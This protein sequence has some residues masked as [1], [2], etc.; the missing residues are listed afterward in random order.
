MQSEHIIE[1][2]T[3]RLYTGDQGQFTQY[4]IKDDDSNLNV[5]SFVSFLNL[6]GIKNKKVEEIDIGE[7]A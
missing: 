4:H 6:H 5:E 2:P 7:I 3:I 1:Y